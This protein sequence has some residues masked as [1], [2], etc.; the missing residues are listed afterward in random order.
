MKK[1]LWA[2]VMCAAVAGAAPRVNADLVRHL[3]TAPPGELTPVLIVMERQVPGE[4]LAALTD[5]LARKQKRLVV[6]RELS[7]VSAESQRDV[8][9]YLNERSASG[10][11]ADVDSLWII[12]AVVAKADRETI[13][14]V[15]ALPGVDFI[16]WDKPVPKEARM[17]V[18][19]GDAPEIVWGVSKIRAPEVWSAGYNGTGVIVCVC[20]GG[21]NYN[22]LDLADH[23]WTN[24][25]YPNHGR[26]FS[27]SDP[28]ATMDTDGHGTHVAGTVASDGTAGSQCGVAPNATIMIAR[29]GNGESTWFQAWQWLVT[30]GADIIQQSWSAKYP[31]SPLYSQHRQASETLAAAGVF[32]ANSCGNQ[33]N[34]LGTYPIPFNIPAPANSPPPWLNPNQTLTGGLAGVLAVGST[35]SGDNLSASSGRGPATWKSTLHPNIP[36]YN[37]YWYN[38]EMGLL[39]PDVLA[40]GVSVKS[41]LY[42]NNSGYTTMSGTSMATP[43]VAGAMALLLDYDP[44]LSLIMMQRALEL[45]A[46]DLGTVT[47][48]ENHYGAGRIDVYAALQ[49]LMNNTAVQLK[50]FRAAGA[51]E[52]VKLAWDCSQGEYA[53]FNIYRGES[54]EA[55]KAGKVNRELITGRP[56][57][58]FTDAKVEAGNTYRYWLEVVPLTGRAVKHGPVKA[59]VGGKTA[60]AFALGAA[61][62]NP[63]S[64]TAKIAYS[65]PAGVGGNAEL[66]VY[67]VAGRKVRTLTSAA[68]IP[69]PGEVVWNLADDTGAPVAPGVYIYRLNASCGTAAKK[70]VVTH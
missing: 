20:D 69:G 21:V 38:P 18:V 14:H 13:E 8:L 43:H 6:E 16:A 31:N 44:N 29:L 50:Y 12:N 60:Y 11:A 49:W 62:P 3:E 27:S 25:S 33:G 19:P 66:V 28:N 53:G 26:N 58:A 23:M 22:H 51:A 41:C 35:D 55:E 46:V 68:A 54:G 5:G 40:P 67:D 47:G 56:P 9:S 42:T 37:D 4:D 52:T 15:S 30:V 63:T 59:A 48:K 2:I 34:Q 57:F 45:S 65:L 24:G 61:Y 39:K 7:A 64:G 32:H 70:M 17:D 10:K 36:P 1:V